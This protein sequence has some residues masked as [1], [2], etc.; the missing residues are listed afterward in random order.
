MTDHLIL[1]IDIGGTTTDAVVVGDDGSVQSHVNLPTEKHNSNAVLGST[2]SAARQA[3][4]AAGAEN[5]HLRAIGVGIPGFVDSTAGTTRLA[6]N[7]GV[8]AADLPIG[9]HIS[10]EFG[11]PTH[12]ENDVRAATHGVY[13]ALIVAEP[14]I[15]DMAFISIGTGIAAG[16]VIGGE[17]HRGVTGVASEIGHTIADPAGPPCACGLNGCLEAI[18]SGGAVARTPWGAVGGMAGLFD[19]AEAGDPGAAG[20]AHQVSTVLARAV[21]GLFV[22]TGVERVVLGGGVINHT[23]RL[24]AGLVA[25]L[26]DLASQSSLAALIDLTSRVLTTDPSL[27]IGAIGAAGLAGKRTGNGSAPRKT[28]TS[29]ATGS[30]N[31]KGR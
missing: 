5:T 18:A 2:V 29:G 20:H 13:D 16:L 26:D 24:V 8:G 7:L 28:T 10:E 15:T 14:H 30:H 19:A 17:L 27:P 11:V 1:G 25:A 3:L 9:R 4:D 21:Y 6:V 31:T 23:P 22:T 12:V